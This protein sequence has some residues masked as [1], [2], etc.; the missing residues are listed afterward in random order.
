M[1]LIL[2]LTKQILFN[3][4]TANR[5]VELLVLL[6]RLKSNWAI[7]LLESTVPSNPCQVDHCS[8]R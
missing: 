3:H 5:V 6:K 1:Y 8:N 4:S 7:H 2:L